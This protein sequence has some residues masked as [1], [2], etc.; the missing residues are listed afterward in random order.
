[1]TIVETILALLNELEAESDTAKID[2]F[3]HYT[4]NGTDKRFTFTQID[5]TSLNVL[6]GRI[7]TGKTVLVNPNYIVYAIPS[8]R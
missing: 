5:P 7:S 1:M 6:K 4:D 3:V 2:V 8:S